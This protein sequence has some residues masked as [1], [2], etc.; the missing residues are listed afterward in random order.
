MPGDWHFQYIH[1][2]KF[3]EL[4]CLR[5]FAKYSIK[6]W[7]VFSKALC[8]WKSN[9]LISLSL[10]IPSITK[11]IL[12]IIFL[13][14]VCLR[15]HQ[16][17]T[18]SLSCPLKFTN[19][20]CVCQSDECQGDHP[21]SY[22]MGCCLVLILQSLLHNWSKCLYI[23]WDLLNDYHIFAYVLNKNFRAYI[24]FI[25]SGPHDSLV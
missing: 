12:C 22:F 5:N 25:Q 14:T 23:L 8:A 16:G 6:S 1:T 9:H 2:L 7:K 17:I 21:Y 11:A 24:A 19:F 13:S 18:K 10:A 15:A 20:L 4:P 3:S